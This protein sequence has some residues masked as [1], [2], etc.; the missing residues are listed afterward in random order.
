MFIFWVVF[1]V[2]VICLFIVNMD[3]IQTS[4]QNT[5]LSDLLLNRPVQRPDVLL[6]GEEAGDDGAETGLPMLPTGSDNLLWESEPFEADLLPLA[7]ETPVLT[8][9]PAVVETPA[10]AD[11]PA[12]LETPVV[13]TVSA[14]EK[15]QTPA[16][17]KP[18]TA[19][20]REN[21]I[22]VLPP[23]PQNSPE[24]SQERGLYLVQ[25]DPDGI[26]LRTRVTR[27]LPVTDSPLVDT[28]NALLQGPSAKENSQG[29][30][31]L[32]P[33]GTRILS[34]IVRGST[35]YINFN[36]N[37]LFNEYGVEGYAGQLRQI[38]WT[39]TEFSNIKDV[40]ILIEGR[41]IDYLGESIWIG[42]PVGRESR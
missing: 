3:N 17:V 1:F 29:L 25:V 7:S 18:P 35:A 41:R 22:S 9:G 27:N 6:L 31:S 40:Q 16:A 11:E 24:V 14:A 37:F 5:G 13:A 23:A 8:D 38:V 21:V 28:L 30:I 4:I 34:V 33:Q 32:I 20:P 12:A 36:E 42:S 2:L 15:T 39:A 26:I 19:A 10:L